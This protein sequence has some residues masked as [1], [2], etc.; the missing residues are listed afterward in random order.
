MAAMSQAESRQPLDLAVEL[1]RK[2]D[3]P[4]AEKLL[5]QISADQPENPQALQLLGAL[6]AQT[7]RS[8]DAIEILT[9]SLS[10]AP[11]SPTALSNLGDALRLQ[12]RV[13]EAIAACQRSLQ[14]RPDSPQTMNNLALA[15][16]D[17]GEIDDA[18]SLLERALAIR[19]D[20]PEAHVNIGLALR[21]K[22]RI[23]AAIDAFRRAIA[24]RPDFALAHLQ[25][26]EVLLLKGDFAEGNSEHEWRHKLMRDQSPNRA[27]FLQTLWAGE[28]LNGKK[29]VLSAEGGFGD[30]LQF[31]RY[32]PLVVARGGRVTLQCQANLHRLFQNLRGYEKLIG[33]D[34]TVR[35]FD[36]HCPSLSLMRAFGTTLQTIPAGV[37]YISAPPELVESWR[38]R[39]A[40][41]SARMKV[42]LVWSGNPNKERRRSLPLSAL[43]DLSRIAGV[44]FYS[45]QT[46]SDAGQA[47][48]WPAGSIRTDFAADMRDF[49]DTAAFMENLDLVITV[50]TAAAHLAGALGRPVWV[51]LPFAPAW[52]WLLDRSDSPWY[53]T[54][55]LFRQTRP[56]DWAGPAQQV[57]R[58]L[59]AHPLLTRRHRAQS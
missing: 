29:I 15:F 11:D 36:F 37:P 28:P 34:E 24:L 2:G 3:F 12:N 26:A 18:V 9:K 55:R 44:E 52:R 6:L 20:L 4:P 43:S 21:Q 49:A 30:V 8:A 32:L 23:E 54:M 56:G 47:A 10:L 35:E 14:I 16:L 59:A 7:G 22:G 5:R 33:T 50:D 25:L 46:G 45:L 51:L 42:G 53:P 40:G 57:A 31:V 48:D 13:P 38:G 19:P 41:G 17:E 27:H 1:L 39:L 58:E